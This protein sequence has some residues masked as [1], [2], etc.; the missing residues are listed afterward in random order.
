MME[1]HDGSG[2]FGKCVVVDDQPNP[3]TGVRDNLKTNE[4]K[5]RTRKEIGISA[6]APLVGDLLPWLV[7]NK[8]LVE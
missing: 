6:V 5:Y 1:P 4:E 2:I 7:W 8:K 3:T